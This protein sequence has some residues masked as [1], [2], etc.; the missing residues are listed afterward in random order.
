MPGGETTNIEVVTSLN[1]YD[2]P[3]DG[4]P[5]EPV[6]VEKS[7]VTNKRTM[8]PTQVTVSDITGREDQFTLDK[9][10]FQLFR[11]ED[12]S[13]C[14]LDG[15][16]DEERIKTEYFAEMEQMMK[17]ATGASRVFIFDHKTR[18]G[19]SNWHNLG[20]GNQ[21]KRGPIF[22]AHVDQSYAGAESL[23]RWLL[24]DEAD[25]LLRRRRWQIVNAWRPIKTVHKDPLAVADA[26][27]VSDD[28]LVAARII[29]PDHQRE[30]WTVKPG[31]GH[32]WYFKY[33]QRPDEV[34][35]IKCFDS[36]VEDGS[37]R[38]VARR[39]P[40]SAFQDP[41]YVQEDHRESIEIRT[42]LFYD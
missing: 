34:L 22:R 36:W 37:G 6:Y 4:S 17:E 3:G 38:P 40:H 19:P 23:L 13:P 18:H 21:A 25:D 9:T 7:T 32:R 26:T 2:D 10:G 16:R 5:P 42:M 12:K 27:S 24:P 41:R 35:L 28:D 29:Y 31:R 8:I 39:A 20:A 11:H 14:R 30:S 33:E 15:Y 1:Y